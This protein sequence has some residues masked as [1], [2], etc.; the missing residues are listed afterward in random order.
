M[1]NKETERTP[2]GGKTITA[3]DWVQG[4]IYFE[5][6]MTPNKGKIKISLQR[7]EELFEQAK[8]MER[9]QIMDAWNDG[10]FG[11]IRKGED[12]SEQYYNETYGKE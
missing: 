6:K 9:S 10:L 4:M 11:S 2:E 12:N 7:T 8:Q 1:E 3:V 5:C